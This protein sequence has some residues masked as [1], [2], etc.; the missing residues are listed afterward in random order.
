MKRYL[1]INGSQEGS[2]A[3]KALSDSGIEFE[4]VLIKNSKEEWPIPALISRE[5]DF[6]GLDEIDEYIHIK[7]S[8][9]K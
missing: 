9:K 1:F 5:G 4:E 3:K 8:T 2:R 6:E 7:T